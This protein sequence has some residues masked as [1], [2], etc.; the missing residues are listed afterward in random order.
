MDGG[1]RFLIPLNEGECMAPLSRECGIALPRPTLLP[2]SDLREPGQNVQQRAIGPAALS[3]RSPGALR[4]L[5]AAPA[6]GCGSVG[7]LTLPLA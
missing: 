6:I 3:W 4:A 7:V 2:D 5:Y 1:L